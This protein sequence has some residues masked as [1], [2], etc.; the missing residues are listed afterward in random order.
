MEPKI[1]LPAHETAP[2]ETAVDSAT[3]TE[4]EGPATESQRAHGLRWIFIGGSG[5]RIGWTVLIFVIMYRLLARCLGTI[6]V[7]FYPAIASRALSPR[8]AMIGELISL[9]AILGAGGLLARIENRKILDYNLSGVRR[10]LNFMSGLAAGFSALSALVSTLALGGWLHFGPVALS[11]MQAMR[12][13]ALWAVFFVFVGLFEEGVFRCYL[14]FTFTRGISFWWA[15]G[16]IGAICLDLLLRS[17][18]YL[19]IVT[20][21]GLS[22]LSSINGNGVTGVYY[23]ALI[24]L[25]PC[26]LLHL[27]KAAGQGFWHAAWVTSTL[28]GFVHTGNNGE[29][30]IGI[31]A[32]AAIGFVFCVSFRVTGSSWWAIGWLASWDWA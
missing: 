25:L 28:F 14:Q 5:L 32:A 21:I 22:P 8:I 23:F 2:T 7:A 31:F 24:G 10:P 1:Q 11:G 3:L 12:Y 20:F 30:W 29:N 6:A 4:I 18:G 17:R 27:K 19:G 26:L 13:A 15:L 16:I 9:L